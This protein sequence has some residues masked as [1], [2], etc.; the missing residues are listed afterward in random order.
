MRDEYTQKG[1]KHV[2]E[3][4]LRDQGY[5]HPFLRLYAT[6][7]RSG[8]ASQLTW[9]MVDSKVTE[10]HFPVEL[11]KNGEDFTLPLVQ[12]WHA[13]VRLRYGPKEIYA[14]AARP[15]L[16]YDRL[17]QPMAAGVALNQDWE[18]TTPT[19]RSAVDC[20]HTIFAAQHAAT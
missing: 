7:M 6:G 15:D 18:S 19:P 13:D 17:S 5:L 16:R 9:D 2:Q 10:L 8:Q 1:G 12:K 4:I 11:T 14:S 3:S 20:D